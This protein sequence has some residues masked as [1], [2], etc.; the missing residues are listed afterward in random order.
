MASSATHTHRILNTSRPPATASALIRTLGIEG[1]SVFRQKPVLHDWLIEN[2][3]S[4]ELRIS[5][6]RNGYGLI[7][8]EVYGPRRL[9]PSA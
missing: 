8:D 5:L 9:R 2:P 3:P 6:R 1:L 4:P 7:L